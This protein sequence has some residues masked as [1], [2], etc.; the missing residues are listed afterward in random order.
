MAGSYPDYP[1][2]RIPYDKDGSVGLV[3]MPAPVQLSPS[4]LAM[5][6]DEYLG[7]NYMDHWSE[8]TTTS[9]FFLL[10]SRP[11]DIDAAYLLCAGDIW[12]SGSAF[13]TSVNTTNGVDGTWVSRGNLPT[14]DRQVPN[15]TYRTDISAETWL[16]IRGLRVDFW[17]GGG[18]CYFEALHLFGEPAPTADL[19]HLNL[20]H[21][22][23][24]E[25]VGPAHFDWGNVS[26]DS[27]EDVT[28][29]VK[30]ASDSST[31]TGI[32][33]SSV[34]QHA[35]DAASVAAAAQQLFSTDGLN[36]YATAAV[37]SLA[38]GQASSLITM[39]RITPSAA[40]LGLTTFRVR[41]EAASWS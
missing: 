7:Y 17:A 25:R 1:S 27:S 39:R 38:P 3:G 12:G 31:A 5:F 9:P 20:W 23:R 34:Q 32:T 41:A 16:G 35:S 15:P 37:A 6:N 30:N 4:A 36:F 8:V 19:T 29:R 22:S 28:F 26:R 33:V 11:M 40:T 10:F 13:S 2:W 18:S 24:D 21:P 14:H